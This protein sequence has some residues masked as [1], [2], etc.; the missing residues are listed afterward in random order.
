[1]GVITV[2]FFNKMSYHRARVKIKRDMVT[3]LQ[4][5]VAIFSETCS[6]S[7]YLPSNRAY[8]RTVLQKYGYIVYL[9]LNPPKMCCRIMNLKQFHVVF[10]DLKPQKS[11]L[12]LVWRHFCLSETMSKLYLSF[13]EPQKS[14]ITFT[15]IGYIV[16]FY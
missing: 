1:M 6:S 12:L 3:F 4:P 2:T 10:H 13:L 15:N 11:Y 8:Y 7:N 14:E 9:V 16:S 5:C